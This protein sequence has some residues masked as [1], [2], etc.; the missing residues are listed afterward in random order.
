MKYFRKVVKKVPKLKPSPVVQQN[1][2]IFSNI[3]SRCAYFGCAS[4]KKAG[5]KIG[6]CKNTFNRR[7]HQGQWKTEELVH[8]AEKLKVSVA[9]LVTDHSKVEEVR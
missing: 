8:A 4:E 6:M 7:K 2:I 9:W 5:E 1:N 3:M